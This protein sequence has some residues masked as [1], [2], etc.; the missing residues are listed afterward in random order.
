[1][2]STPQL[3]SLL[4]KAACPEQ[5]PDKLQAG[6]GV[7]PS[8]SVW[9]SFLVSV[10]RSSESGWCSYISSSEAASNLSFHFRGDQ[11]LHSVHSL[12]FQI[13]TEDLTVRF[14]ISSMRACLKVSLT[15][16]LLPS[17]SCCLRSWFLMPLLHSGHPQHL[18][19]NSHS[20]GVPR[21]TLSLPDDHVPCAVQE[22]HVCYLQVVANFCWGPPRPGSISSAISHAQWLD[23]G[24]HISLQVLQ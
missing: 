18:F 24:P 2:V 8:T 6:P 21:T 5:L 15:F 20:I 1:M 19:P 7:P 22:W 9:G 13:L 17:H 11:S 4:L 3:L 23:V 14:M 16:P 12:S 10:D